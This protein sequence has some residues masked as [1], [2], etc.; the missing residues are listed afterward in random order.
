MTREEYYAS[1]EAYKEN[2]IEHH[3]ILG[4]KWGVRRYQNY[5]GTLTKAGAA[6]VKEK[7]DIHDSNQKNM[8]NLGWDKKTIRTVNKYNKTQ[9]S[10][11]YDKLKGYKKADK[12][13]KLFLKGERIG[14]HENTQSGLRRTAKVIGTIGGVGVVAD[15]WIN[16]LNG[17]SLTKNFAEAIL[18]RDL[19]RLKNI[20]TI[21][22]IAGVTLGASVAVSA[23][24]A[25]HRLY[26]NH[27]NDLLRNYYMN[28]NRYNVKKEKGL[29]Y[30]TGIKETAKKAAKTA[31][32]VGMGG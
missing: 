17:K 30:D 23:I 29:L 5:D 13:Q 16:M 3:G 10:K 21:G 27:R 22:K 15:N 4:M 2:Y 24:A 19:S 12:G 6:R 28:S 20:G 14:G 9:I 7:L 32:R 8:K 18:N 11:E 25:G 31:V 26:S 1:L